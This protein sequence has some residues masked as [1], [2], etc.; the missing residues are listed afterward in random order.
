MQHEKKDFCVLILAAGKGTRMRSKKPKVLH[1]ILEEVLLYYPLSEL[2]SAGLE[3]I[4]VM[5]GF[6]GESVEEWIKNQFPEVNVLWQREQHGTGH[7]AKLAQEWWEEYEN[8]II[9]P[10]DTPLIRAETLLKF[11]YAYREK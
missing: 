11:K 9:L 6:S 1:T 7:A 4:S 3:D 5:V 2:R 8:V 10:G